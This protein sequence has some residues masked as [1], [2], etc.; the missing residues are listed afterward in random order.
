MSAIVISLGDPAGIGPEVTTKAISKIKEHQ[1]IVLV[2]HQQSLKEFK[3]FESTIQPNQIYAATID[4]HHQPINAPDHKI[5]GLIAYESIKKALSICATHNIKNFVTAPISK[6]SFLAAKIPYTGHTSLLKDH[7]KIQTASMAFYSKELAIVLATIHI[8]L[9]DV[10]KSLTSTIINQSITN[11]ELFAT[12][13]GIEKPRIGVA[14]LNPHASE[15]GQFGTFETNILEPLIKSYQSQDST[16]IGPISPDVI[17]RQAYDGEFD[18]VVALYHDQGLIPLKLLAFDTAVNV[19]V[20]LPIC[21]T[22]PDHGTAYDIAGKNIANPNS[23]LAA[24][25]YCLDQ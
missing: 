21:R 17:F 10:E 16:I 1:G 23:M 2:G 25:K 5:N 9:M 19:T 14:G 3:A 7:F 24:I 11:A 4:T 22:S 8:P 15:N 13:L 6:A 20:G 12:Q 18:I